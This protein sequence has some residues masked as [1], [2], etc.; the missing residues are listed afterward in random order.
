MLLMGFS[1]R[2]IE[3]LKR[4]Q[5]EMELRFPDEDVGVSE[6]FDDGVYAESRTRCMC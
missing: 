4:H 6:G 1:M 3:A 5:V 2:G